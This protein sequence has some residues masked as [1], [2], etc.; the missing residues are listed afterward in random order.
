MAKNWTS[1]KLLKTKKEV[2]EKPELFELMAAFTNCM[3]QCP[4]ADYGSKLE[5]QF[6]LVYCVTIRR[7]QVTGSIAQP[8][9]RQV[10]KL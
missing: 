4:K 2:R 5:L 6:S 1:Y 8:N 9:E 3:L 7:L 10:N